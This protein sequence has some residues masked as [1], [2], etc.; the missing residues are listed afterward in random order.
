[1]LSST[2][3]DKVWSIFPDVGKVAAGEVEGSEF[4]LCRLCIR[5]CADMYVQCRVITQ[6][7]KGEVEEREGGRDGEGLR[8]KGGKEGG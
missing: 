2:F 8:K 1:M 3:T 5:V 6:I 4:L 7:E